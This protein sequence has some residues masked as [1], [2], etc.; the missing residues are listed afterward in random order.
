MNNNKEILINESKNKENINNNNI[1]KS[2]ND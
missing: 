2:Q 1:N